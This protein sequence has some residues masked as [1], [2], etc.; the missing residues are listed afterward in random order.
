MLALTHPPPPPPLQTTADGAEHHFLASSEG[1]G[2]VREWLA[3]VQSALVASSG[4]GLLAEGMGAADGMVLPA[5][6]AQAPTARGPPGLGALPTTASGRD[7]LRGV[8]E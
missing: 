2:G 4:R 8:L 3:V 5:A 6:E 7:L 1:E